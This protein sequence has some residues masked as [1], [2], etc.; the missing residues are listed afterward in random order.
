MVIEELTKEREVTHESRQVAKCL[1]AGE[2]DATTAVVISNRADAHAL[3]RARDAGIEALHVSPHAFADRDAFDC[4][5][6]DLLRERR[7]TLVCLD[8]Q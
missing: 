5:I 7:V 1:A 3:Q 8:G 4:A 6:A 2:I